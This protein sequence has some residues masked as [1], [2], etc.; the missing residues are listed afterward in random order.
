MLRLESCEIENGGFVLA[1]DLQIEAGVKLAVIGPSGAGKSTLI[2]AIAGFLPLRRGRMTWQDGD[3]TELAP[4]QRPVA[5]LFQDG[6]LFP[7]LTVAQNAGLGLRPNLRLSHAEQ[8]RVQQALARV[9]LG[10]LAARKPAELSGG[11]K[12]GWRWHGCCCS[13]AISCCW[14]SPLRRWARR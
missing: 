3:M 2:E 12:A 9:G 11:S 8:D 10:D 1:A 13:S 4:G 7:H 6:N 14:M 5:M